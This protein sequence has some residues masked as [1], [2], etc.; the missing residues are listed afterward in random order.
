[1]YELQQENSNN[2]TINTSS[3]NYIEKPYPTTIPPWDR[4]DSK[5][6]AA[7]NGQDE[8][9]TPAVDSHRLFRFMTDRVDELFLISFHLTIFLVKALKRQ[10]DMG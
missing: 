6:G 4:A 3:G 2:D 7:V 5:T 8:R 10:D 1:M 9:A